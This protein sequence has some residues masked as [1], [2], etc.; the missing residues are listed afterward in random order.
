MKTSSVC[1]LVGVLWLA[2]CSEGKNSDVIGSVQSYQVV[3]AKALDDVDEVRDAFIDQQ[4]NLWVLGKSQ[5]FIRI[6]DS[7]GR[8]V[9]EGGVRGRGPTDL[10][11]PL[12]FVYPTDLGISQPL[13]LDI[14]RHDLLVLNEKLSVGSSRSARTVIGNMRADLISLVSQ[15]PNAAAVKGDTLLTVRVDRSAGTA[16]DL[17]AQ[18]VV[19][20]IGDQSTVL[21]YSPLNRSTRLSWLVGYPLWDSCSDGSLIGVDADGKKMLR[22]YSDG[23]VDGFF[24]PSRPRTPTLESDLFSLYM[25]HLKAEY[26]DMG[27]P[28]PPF[29][30]L[31]RSAKR[32]AA[33]AGLKLADSLPVFAKLYCLNENTVLMKYF[34]LDAP[35]SGK[36]S[37]IRVRGHSVDAHRFPHGFQPL[38]SDGGYFIGLLYDSLQVASLVTIKPQ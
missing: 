33:N 32:I 12:S 9:A 22:V 31:Q 38:S 35:Q 5:P 3:S 28:V 14:G 4:N 15:L 17:T 34:S 25:E 19:R 23:R 18:S 30:D 6:Y 20:T 13:V 24:L 26:R 36:E 11:F 27:K 21:W 1:K 2:A 7:E 16:I 8:R 37:W 10:L 29:E